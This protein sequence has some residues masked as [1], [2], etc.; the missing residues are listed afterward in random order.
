M[1]GR[2][3]TGTT[4][5][6]WHTDGPCARTFGYARLRTPTHNYNHPKNGS[7]KIAFNCC[8]NRAASAPLM[9]R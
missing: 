4:D 9:T 5:Y 7:S 2:I 1:Y 3:P 6:P 8:K